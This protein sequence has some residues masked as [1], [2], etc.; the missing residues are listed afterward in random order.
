MPRARDTICIVPWCKRPTV[1]HGGL[2]C[3]KHSYLEKREDIPAPEQ[4]NVWAESCHAPLWV[5]CDNYDVTDPEGYYTGEP[6]APIN[7]K[8]RYVRNRAR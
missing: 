2:Y 4:V 8:R 1:T 6:P 3:H 7:G 5:T